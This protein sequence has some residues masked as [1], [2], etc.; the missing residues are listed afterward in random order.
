MMGLEYPEETKASFVV[1][2][3]QLVNEGSTVG[4]AIGDWVDLVYRGISKRD[5]ARA[6]VSLRSRYYAWRHLFHRRI[7][8][9]FA[10]P[11]SRRAPVKGVVAFGPMRVRGSGELEPLLSNLT[12]RPLAVGRPRAS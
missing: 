3:V 4:E 7:D 1:W 2:V 11:I 6:I 9:H 5:R 10:V 8:P 12:T